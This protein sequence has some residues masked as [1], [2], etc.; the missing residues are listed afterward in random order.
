MKIY[1]G[2]CLSKKNSRYLNIF[3]DSLVKIEKLNNSNLSF[4]FILE[5]KNIDSKYIINKK[6][7][8]KHNYRIIL[9][10]K[11]G[12]PECRNVFIR[13]LMKNSSDYAGF[14]DD[15][16]VISSKWLINMVKFIKKNNCDIVGGPQY[17]KTTNKYFSHLFRLIEPQRNHNQSVKWIATNNSFFKSS[18]IKETKIRF[19]ENLNKVGGSDQLFFK[20]LI[21]KNKICKWN[22]NS[23]V[24][25]TIQE[26]RENLVWFLKRNLRYGYSGNYI[27]KSIHG[28]ILGTIINIFKAVFYLLLSI[29]YFMTFFLNKNLF[30][31]L[32][33]LFR[34]LG[35][36]L[37]CFNYI[38]KK[39]I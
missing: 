31:S 3:L 13:F 5:K 21:L 22:L 1:I 11:S 15:D 39:Y 6:L 28:K 14:I 20:K 2:I 19:D 25:E 10:N 24:T 37:G 26:E 17:H 29:F 30:K 36:F 12:I 33:Y 32:F 8:K 16:C 4:V 9:T 7:S 23:F 27:D 18:I 34:S 38:P 35:R